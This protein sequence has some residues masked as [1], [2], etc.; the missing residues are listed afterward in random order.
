MASLDKGPT[1]RDQNLNGKMI[2]DRAEKWPT[3]RS[4]Q[5]IFGQQI[6]G[7]EKIIIF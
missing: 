4:Q 3:A 6:F 5:Q 1:K 2:V 7:L